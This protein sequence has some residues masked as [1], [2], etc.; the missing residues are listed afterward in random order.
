[1]VERRGELALLLALGFGKRRVVGLVIM[2]NGVLLVAGLLSGT[3]AALVAVAPHLAS[4]SAEVRWGSLVATLA[5][6]FV[7]GLVSCLIA[8]A[9][10]VRSE[11][12]SALRRE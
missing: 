3:V 11:L 2:E 10:S 12:L 6:C 1:V 7:I 9:S 4:G 5:A 8:A